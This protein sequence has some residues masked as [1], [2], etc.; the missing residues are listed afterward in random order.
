MLVINGTF[1]QARSMSYE[2][3]NIFD[4]L[5]LLHFVDVPFMTAK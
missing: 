1:D 2:N 4:L 3:A 5:E